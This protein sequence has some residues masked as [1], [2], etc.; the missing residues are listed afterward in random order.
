MFLPPNSE[1]I[2]DYTTLYD[3]NQ[4]ANL[5]N[6]VHPTK[7]FFVNFVSCSRLILYCAY[8]ALKTANK[9]LFSVVFQ[10]G[11][12]EYGIKS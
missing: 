12:K 6:W 8:T 11:V 4:N 1:V 9:S 5:F 7:Y 10:V 2:L 3:G